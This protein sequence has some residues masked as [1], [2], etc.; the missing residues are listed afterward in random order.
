MFSL[1]DYSLEPAAKA[2]SFIVSY[3]EPESKAMLTVGP[4]N[5]KQASF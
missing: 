2:K 5:S 3:I 1:L 4:G